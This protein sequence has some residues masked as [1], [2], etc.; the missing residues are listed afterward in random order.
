VVNEA[1]SRGV[2][3]PWLI[4]TQLG[5]LLQTFARATP[6]VCVG[7]LDDGVAAATREGDSAGVAFARWVLGSFQL[8]LGKAVEARSLIEEAASEFERTGDPD[9]IG[10]CH[11]DLGWVAVA[12]GDLDRAQRHFERIVHLARHHRLWE[13]L[14]PHVL[15]GAAPV[16]ALREPERGR[17]LAEEAV[18]HARLLPGQMI[19]V[20]TL[21]RSAETDIVSGAPRRATAA[22]RELLGL[23]RDVHARRWMADAL[24][25][26]AMLAGA[27]SADEWAARLLG[28]SAV[29][30][31]ELG[32]TLGGVRVV[33]GDVRRCCD[34]IELA[35]GAEH[36]AEVE[37][38]GRTASTDDIIAETL[39]WLNA[40]VEDSPE[41][42]RR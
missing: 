40:E 27:G 4:L 26:V 25:M 22:L 6:D 14:T 31:D 19:L 10:W 2:P 3:V 23:L 17:Q 28:A 11:H 42:R 39:A 36:F 38:L 32:E 18:G 7:L 41:R 33:A 24:E 12:E 13:W 34:R 37:Q 16:I 8:M 5:M 21:A 30:R 29:L 1:R 15:A 35:L 20:M 9:G